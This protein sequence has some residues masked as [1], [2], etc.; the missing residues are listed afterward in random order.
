[1]DTNPNVVSGAC[2]GDQCIYDHHTW[3]ND[4]LPVCR[5]CGALHPVWE[6]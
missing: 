1:M 4:W 5:N 2:C 6:T 3:S